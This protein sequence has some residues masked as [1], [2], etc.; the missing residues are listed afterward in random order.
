MT[1]GTLSFPPQPLLPEHQLQHHVL[2]VE[3][4]QGPEE[5][6]GHH[7][8]LGTVQGIRG[9]VERAGAVPPTPRQGRGQGWG[10]GR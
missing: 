5:A 10:D 7:A 4:E 9:A 6:Q 2:T 8:Q 3:A 1:P